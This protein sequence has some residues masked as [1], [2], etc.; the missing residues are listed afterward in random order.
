M[1]RLKALA[2]AIGL[3]GL[4]TV[5]ASPLVA[6]EPDRCSDIRS[7]RAE[8]AALA[9]R[10]AFAQ[11]WAAMQ[12]ALDLYNAFDSLYRENCSL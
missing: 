9:W 2:V 7:G 4:T 6:D 1:R 10:F 11:D 12:L 3:V 8:A 5:W